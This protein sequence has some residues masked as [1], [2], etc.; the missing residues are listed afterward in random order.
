L[1]IIRLAR[2]RLREVH[3]VKIILHIL[4]L[5]I[6]KY[7]LAY[8]CK[9]NVMRLGRRQLASLLELDQGYATG[10]SGLVNYREIPIEAVDEE[11][12]LAVG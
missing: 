1:V 12:Y 4:N 5:E 10:I 6:D 7:K 8:G 2:E 11:C 3:F 9:P